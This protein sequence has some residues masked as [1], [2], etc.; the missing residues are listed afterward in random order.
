MMDS[1]LKSYTARP[2]MHNYFDFSDTQAANS[3]LSDPRYTGIPGM[4][5]TISYKNIGSHMK[6]VY[7]PW[8]CDFSDNRVKEA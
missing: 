4:R 1:G 8:R 2:E 5:S 6:L 7:A 3:D